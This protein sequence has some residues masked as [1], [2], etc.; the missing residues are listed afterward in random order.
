MHDPHDEVGLHLLPDDERHARLL[1][2]IPA[3]PFRLRAAPS[4][5]IFDCLPVHCAGGRSGFSSPPFAILQSIA[6]RH[7]PQPRYDDAADDSGLRG[8]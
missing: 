4:P 1:L 3:D 5:P 7:S 8:D 2:L 6:L